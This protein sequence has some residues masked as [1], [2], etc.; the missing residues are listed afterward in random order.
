M[1]RGPHLTRNLGQRAELQ[2][3]PNGPHGHV[4]STNSRAAA[5]WKARAGGSRAAPDVPCCRGPHPNAGWSGR[6]PTA[7][8]EP[9]REEMTCV[10]SSRRRLRARP[11]AWLAAR[12]PSSSAIS[13]RSRSR[14]SISATRPIMLVGAGRQHHRRGRHRRHHHGGRPV[15]A[16]ARQDQ[17]GDHRDLA[18]ADQVPDQHPFPRR[19]HRRQRPVPGRRRHRRGAGQRPPAARR[20]HHQRHHRRQDAASRRRRNPEGN[21]C[22]R[23][24]APSKPAAAWRSS[25]TSTTPTPTATPRST[26][27]T[28]MC[29]AT[30]DVFN[31]RKN[32]QSIDFANGG[33]IHGII[34][35]RRRV[36][37]KAGQRRDQDR[38][39]PWRARAPSAD[40]AEYQA[41]AGDRARPYR[42]AVQRR[43]VRGRGDRDA[44][45]RRPRQDLGRQR[46]RPPRHFIKMV[47]NSFKR[48]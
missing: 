18:A 30:G 33:D 13:A 28:P 38:A 39:R 4:S 6:R 11:C 45:A 41:M 27:P 1:A 25:P 48:S 40:V 20:R 46:R 23:L 42:D 10:G 24:D 3:V 2:L 43:Q 19:P 7:L 12:S 44:A 21:L 26:S 22:R 34:R 16:A 5:A 31:N 37:C 32:Y 35:G 47:Y 8:R 36:T 17:G 14:P 29:S 9:S 15:R